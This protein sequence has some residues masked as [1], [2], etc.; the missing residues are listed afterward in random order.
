MKLT[1]AQAELA[2]TETQLAILAAELDH[3]RENNPGAVPEIEE[4]IARLGN[5]ARSL[6]DSGVTLPAAAEAT[7]NEPKA[8][9]KKSKK[10]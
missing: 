3:A 6:R 10:T 7:E 9:R 5:Y 8:A 1:H 4:K 2:N